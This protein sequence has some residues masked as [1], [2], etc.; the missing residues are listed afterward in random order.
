M[1]FHVCYYH[2]VWTTKNRIPWSISGM[3]RHLIE[4]VEQKSQGLKSRVECVNAWMNHIR[5]AVQIHPTLAISEWVRQVKGYSSF[6][7]N[8]LYPDAA[9]PFRWQESYGVMTF[10]TKQLPFITTYIEHQKQ[11]HE[12][13]T[14]YMYLENTGQDSER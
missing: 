1:P 14:T 2:V 6:H 13:Q 11:H 3:E 5:V 7:I 12:M 9:E 10:G 4:S 8:R